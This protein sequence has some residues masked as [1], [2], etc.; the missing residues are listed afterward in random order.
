MVVGPGLAADNR[1]FGQL[2]A[3]LR[4]HAGLSRADAA[5]ALGVTAEYLRLIERGKRTPAL[6][7]MRSF[8]DAYRADGAV[9]KL[10]P[11]GDTPDLIVLD[12]LNDEP[13]IVEFKSRIREARRISAKP[14]RSQ[15]E[16][17]SVNLPA[18]LG[19]G[20]AM[21]RA[22]ELGIVVSLLTQADDATI[23]E[24]RDLLEA[25]AGKGGDTET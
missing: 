21:D 23:R 6:G 25:H 20:H 11:G 7:Q 18:R 14:R 5:E 22:V 8:I 4:E 2:L 17:G 3:R 12:P 10:Q 15:A 19:A 9:G 1:R 13:V 16:R 24:V